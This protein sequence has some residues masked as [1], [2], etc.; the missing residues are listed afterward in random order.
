MNA[1]RT[2]RILTTVLIG[3]LAVPLMYGVL[4]L[5]PPGQA[6]APAH[7]NV[8]A[9]YIEHGAEHGGSENLVTGVLLNYRALD[10]FGEVLVIFT[11]WL[12]VAAVA[13]TARQTGHESTPPSPI[14]DYVIRM[15]APFIAVFALFVIVNGHVLPGGGFQGGVL[16]GAMLILLSLAHGGEPVADVVSLRTW[17]W[18]RAAGVLV[19][20]LVALLGLPLTGYLFGLPTDPTLRHALMIVLELGIGIGGGAVLGGLYFSIAGVERS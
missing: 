1:W 14:V 18:L 20:A 17:I 10:T 19:F 11:A 9:K 4:H 6:D 8:S 12:A 13:G 3:A 16:L 7:S 15:L 2:G 5:P